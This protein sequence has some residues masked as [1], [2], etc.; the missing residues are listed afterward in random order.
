LNEAIEV[1]DVVIRPATPA[2]AAAIAQ[3]RVDAWRVTY[4]GM[5]PESYLAAMK[6]EDSAAM[7]LRVL[8]ANAEA[9]CVFV[10]ED[11]GA[12]VGFASGNRL[13][14]PKHGF[15]AELS[16]IY[17]ARDHQRSGIGTR[18]LGAVAG[19]LQ[20]RGATGLLT[21]VIAGNRPAR[22]FYEQLGATLLVEQPFQWDGLDL[23]ETG[24]GWTNLGA[25]LSAC[26]A[27]RALH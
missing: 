4:R 11:D 12:V 8:S 1:A 9:V 2:D 18:L 23:V 20:T 10:A 13:A 19:T 25:L 21:W 26:A 22:T 16:A 14:P 7:W 17:L 15:D 5:I 24:Y 27:A 6:V 3:V